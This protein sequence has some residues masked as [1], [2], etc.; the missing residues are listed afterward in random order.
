V[1]LLACV[2]CIGCWIYYWV[3]LRRVTNLLEAP[4]PVP[5]I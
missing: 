5:S 2:V 3:L 1:G 4:A